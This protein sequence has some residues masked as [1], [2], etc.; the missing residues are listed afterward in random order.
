MTWLLD[1]DGVVWL[2]DQPI[3]G[4]AEAIARLRDTGEKVAFLTNN[5]WPR[6]DEHVAKLGAMGVK[7][8][9][10][11]VVTSSMAAASLVSPGEKVLVLGGPGLKEELARR[12][13]EV[14]EPGAKDSSSV[15]SV[16]VGIDLSFS[17]ARLTAATTALRSGGVRLI[18]TNE[19]ATLPT[20]QGVVP[21]AGSVVAA[22][23]TA[24]GVEPI[25]AGKPHEATARLVRERFTDVSMM[26][27]DRPSTD[28]AFARQLGVR[29]GLVLT[30]VTA[31]G[32]GPL[33]PSP[34]LEAD[35]L[36]RLVSLAT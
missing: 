35:D 33:N 20:A 34:D 23:A 30:G 28:G 36:A 27:G 10:E 1:C 22:V 24:G 3:A 25:V 7:A 26:V 16:V 11:E 4:A 32:H 18:A 29:F 6:V 21:G 19:D 13:A 5:S 9:P 2:A 15:E 8:S 14:L 12:G 17:Y 31:K